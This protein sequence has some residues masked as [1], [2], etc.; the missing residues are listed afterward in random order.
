[1]KY[2]TIYNLCC[3]YY[4]NEELPVK[5]I[6][7]DNGK[8]YYRVK[9]N[10]LNYMY[11][12]KKGD[13]LS[14]TNKL[15]KLKI[16]MCYYSEDILD[17]TEKKYLKGVI[18]PFRN[19]VSYIIKKEYYGYEYISIE[20]KEITNSINYIYLPN[21]KSNTMYKGMEIDREYSLKEL[22]I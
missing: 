4:N 1:M 5:I 16:L 17:E 15:D 9:H 22:G 2:S 3:D 19:Q 8:V 6:R 21:F 12:D 18:R 10:D 20:Y 13:F 14:F 11:R 7:Y